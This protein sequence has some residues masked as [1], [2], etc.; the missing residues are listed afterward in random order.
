MK[1]TAIVLGVALVSFGLVAAT[2]CQGAYPPEL[3]M[4]TVLTVKAADAIEADYQD[5]ILAAANEIESKGLEILRREMDSRVAAATDSRGTLA[6]DDVRAMIQFV[7]DQQ[8]AIHQ[9]RT[10]KVDQM[11]RSPNLEILHKLNDR[12][13]AYLK[14][15]SDGAA[16]IKE[17]L[18]IVVP[19][20]VVAK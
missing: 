8:A 16:A 10:D 6:P 15:S 19:T 2:S 14:H 7:Q 3:E 5:A 20:K 13:G 12:L 18:D 17:M 11:R 1:S 4:A 9:A